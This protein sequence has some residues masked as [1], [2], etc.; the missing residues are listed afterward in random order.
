MKPPSCPP[1]GVNNDFLI[2]THDRLALLYN[3]RSPMEN[4]HAASAWMLLTD[5]K[6][7]FLEKMPAK[8]CV[9]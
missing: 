2:K 8:V 3:D 7:H 4:H 1:P 6:Y 5:S 9:L